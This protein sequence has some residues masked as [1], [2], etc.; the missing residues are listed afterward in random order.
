MEQMILII[1]R[2]SDRYYYQWVGTSM[3]RL[4]PPYAPVT[5]K[6]TGQSIIPR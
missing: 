4:N 5:V 6:V 3:I 2:L 1:F